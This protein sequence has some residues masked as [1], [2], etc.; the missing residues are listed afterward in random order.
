MGEAES[1]TKLLRT[2][3]RARRAPA[4][5]PNPSKLAAAAGVDGTR[6]KSWL[7]EHY[8]MTPRA[9]LERARLAAATSRLKGRGWRDTPDRVGYEREDTFISAFKRHHGMTPDAYAALR[10]RSEYLFELPR[11]Y[12]PEGVLSLLGRD[13]GSRTQGLTPNGIWKNFAVKGVAVRLAI[14]FKGNAAQVA[15]A[16]KGDAL[17]RESAWSSVEV[18]RRLLGLGAPRPS[19]RA[20]K[21][22]PWCRI[23]GTSEHHYPALYAEPFEALTWAIVGQQIN[24]KFAAT[25][26][27]RL[28]DH[29]TGSDALPLMPTPAQLA[30]ADPAPLTKLQLSRAKAGTLVRVSRAIVAGDLALDELHHLGAPAARA[31]LIH[32]KG[33]GP[34]TAE[35]LAL[36]G[37]G[38]AD[39]LPVGDAGLAA[40]VRTAFGLEARPAAGTI[41][42]LAKPFAPHRSLATHFFWRSAV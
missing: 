39:C 5:F 24:L 34:W 21:L 13:E 8:H 28:T 7:A 33:I 36:R 31:A 6:L 14:E 20:L 17:P 10:G 41:A 2:V 30:E 4:E 3:E 26:I 16:S 32:Y 42:A 37:F 9:W 35:Y 23:P 1:D 15:L 22:D 29:Y 38:F 18:V 11:R 12:R 27:R 25:L 19:G 40:G